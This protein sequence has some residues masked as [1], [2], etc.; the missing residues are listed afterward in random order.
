[1]SPAAHPKKPATCSRIRPNT[2]ASTTAKAMPTDQQRGDQ[3]RAFGRDDVVMDDVDDAASMILARA[4][5][6]RED[7]RGKDAN[8]IGP[9]ILQKPRAPRRE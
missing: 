2:S 4:Y 6:G 3:G 5:G 1:M 7:R 8:P 9:K